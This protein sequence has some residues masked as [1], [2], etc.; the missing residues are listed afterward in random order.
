LASGERVDQENSK[1]VSEVFKVVDQK[2]E[3]K[4]SDIFKRVDQ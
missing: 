1:N 4:A 2:C 3:I